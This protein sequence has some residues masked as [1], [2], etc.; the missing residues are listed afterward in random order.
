MSGKPIQIGGDF[1][2][3]R[4]DYGGQLFMT[5]VGDAGGMER[6]TATILNNQQ[7]HCGIAEDGKWASPP[8]PYAPGLNVKVVMIDNT[9][10]SHEIRTTLPG[11]DQLGP[12]FGP[13]WEGFAPVN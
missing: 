12:V 8:M 4:L 2:P 9:G 13:G 3:I 1:T 6:I 5:L 10:K 7:Y 11:P